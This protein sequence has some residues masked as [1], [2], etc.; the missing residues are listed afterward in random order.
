MTFIII[1]IVVV[2]LEKLFEYGQNRH[3]RNRIKFNEER[4][5][6]NLEEMEKRKFK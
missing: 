1:V 6:R 3:H 2:V 5:K 4:V